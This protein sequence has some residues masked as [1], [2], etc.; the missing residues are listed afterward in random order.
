MKVSITNKTGD[1]QDTKIIAEDGREL[2]DL[3][4][5][6]KVV[7]EVGEFIKATMTINYFDE[8]NIE[9]VAVELSKS[10]Q[11]ILKELGYVKQGVNVKA[12]PPACTKCG[13][14][15]AFSLLDDSGR[16][17]KCGVK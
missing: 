5:V 14:L 9:G 7:L 12:E 4:A 15:G 2:Q 6:E 3:L 8:I 10:T 1:V 17:R 13:T 16:C 11:K